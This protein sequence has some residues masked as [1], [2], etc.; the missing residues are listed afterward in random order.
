MLTLSLNCVH[1]I[2]VHI[3]KH[4]KYET[5]C[6]ECVSRILI[7]CVVIAVVEE[8]YFMEQQIQKKTGYTVPVYDS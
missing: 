8:T 4:Y 2:F 3:T 1:Y 7:S 6:C 5:L